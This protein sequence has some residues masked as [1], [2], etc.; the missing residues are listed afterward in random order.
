MRVLTSKDGDFSSYFDKIN[1]ETI[2]NTT[3]KEIIS[4]HH[5]K[6]ANRGKIYGQPAL[7]H[8]FGFWITF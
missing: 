3:L 5:T 4:D 2:K 7:E 1:Q 8:I 6:Q